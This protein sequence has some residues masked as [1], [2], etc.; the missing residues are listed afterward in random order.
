[1]T[2]DQRK[3]S[4]ANV[5]LDAVVAYDEDRGESAT[6]ESAVKLALQRLAEIDAIEGYY[7]D[8]T[9]AVHVRI[10]PLL[11][12][13]LPLLFALLTQLA[14]ERAVSREAVVNVVRQHL[15]DNVF[16]G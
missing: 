2:P 11:G 3:L 16:R 6:N 4:A 1:M 15:R 5:L 8:E 13:V 7:D 12:G 14:N 10:D 9:G